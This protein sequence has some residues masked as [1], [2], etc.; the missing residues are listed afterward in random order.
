VA[1]TVRSTIIEH[2]R[3]D[4]MMDRMTD[5]P[6]VIDRHGGAIRRDSPGVS[7]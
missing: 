6:D 7:A 5:L 2:R 3:S 1:D 4:E